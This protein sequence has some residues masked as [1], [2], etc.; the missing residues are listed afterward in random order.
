M[1]GKAADGQTRPQVGAAPEPRGSLTVMQIS[2]RLHCTI[3]APDLRQKDA[4][5]PRRR[6][7]RPPL[8]NRHKK[9]PPLLSKAVFWQ[10]VP[11]R[12]GA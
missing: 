9:R 12:R 4:A 10:T 1:R 6:V 3:F 7:D 5:T 2:R 11:R 8:R